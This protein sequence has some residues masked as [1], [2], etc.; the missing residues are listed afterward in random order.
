MNTLASTK[1]FPEEFQF[2]DPLLTEICSSADVVE[3]TKGETITEQFKSA[4]ELYLL[5]DGEIEH[6]I[7]LPDNERNISVANINSPGRAVGWSGYFKP[8]RYATEARAVTNAKLL[9]WDFSSINALIADNI[10]LHNAFLSLFI[11]SSYELILNT[12]GNYQ[13]PNQDVSTRKLYENGSEHDRFGQHSNLLI[14]SLLLSDLFHE[15]SLHEIIKLAKKSWLSSIGAGETIF[16]AGESS[17]TTA[18][19]C[20]W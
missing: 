14:E 5:F 19:T 1:R 20:E 12:S 17:D 11:E 9:R 15:V 13:H 8:H 2:E 18:I 4:S 10:D 3:F 6:Q 7:S 16:Q